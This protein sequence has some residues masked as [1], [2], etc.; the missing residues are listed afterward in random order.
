MSF[1]IRA[2]KKQSSS[3]ITSLP[4]DVII[5]ILARVP[6]GDYPKLSLVSK[7][8]RSLVES[9][10]I[11]ARRSLLGCT[12]HCLY[13]VIFNEETWDYEWYILRRKVNGNR[14][15]VPIPSLP[16]IPRGVSFVRVGSKIYVFGGSDQNY[17]ALSIDCRSHTMQTLPSMPMPISYTIAN[18]IDGRIYVIGNFD[19]LKVM[20][21]FNTATQMWEP[22][23]IKVDIELGNTWRGSVVM[24]E[25]MYTRDY[26]YSFVYDPKKSKWDKD[27]VLNSKKWKHACVVDDVLYYYDGEENEIRAYDPKQKYWR[28]VKG[29]EEFLPETA[30]Y[31]RWS[32]T[33][34][35]DGKLVLFL[36]KCEEKTCEIRCAEISL[37]RHQR[38]EIWGKVAWFDQVL[39]SGNLSLVKPLAVMV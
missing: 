27:E 2:K 12:E 36:T 10:E 8:F 32:N 28:V 5:D 22:E 30:R 23:I 13:A 7:H 6:R 35:Y 29:L 9:S 20:V 37:E 14:H 1:E 11:Y 16:D 38:K 26:G 34:D 15:L 25:K 18:I 3:L 17:I 19:F 33:V 24:A 4:E 21:V 31:S 39:T